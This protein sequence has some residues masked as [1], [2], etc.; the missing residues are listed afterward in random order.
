M[1]TLQRAVCRGCRRRN[2]LGTDLYHEV[3]DENAG[4][5]IEPVCEAQERGHSRHAVAPLD[6]GDEGGVQ[7]GC[8]G[9]G[10]L[11]Q[12]GGQAGLSDSLPE[13]HGHGLVTV[14]LSRG[15][16]PASDRTSCAGTIAY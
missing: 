11:G 15:H 1:D 12:A 6:V 3:V 5:D 14:A 4:R 13:R 8:L 9:E 2:R 16:R 10:L 7:T